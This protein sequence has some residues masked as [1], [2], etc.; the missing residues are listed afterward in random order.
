[1][2]APAR[3]GPPTA[4][5]RRA[6]GNVAQ[7]RVD[8]ST[9][10]ALS[11]ELAGD[12]RR[13]AF[14]ARFPGFE[15][16]E[17][18]YAQEVAQAAGVVEHHAVS[19]TADEALADLEQLVLDEEE[20][21]GSLSVYAQWRVMSEAKD[22]GVVVL[23]DG[24][25]DELFGGYPISEGF[26]LRATGPRE[27]A[28]KLATRPARFGVL[29]RSLA[30]DFLPWALRRAYW[31]RIASPYS[32]DEAARRA[33]TVR[34]RRPPWMRREDL[35]VREPD[36][37]VR[38]EPAPPPALRGQEQHGLE[39]RA[40]PSVPRPAPGRASH[41]RC[42]R[43]TSTATGRASRSCV[44]S[45]AGACP[46]PSS[47]AASRSASSPH[48]PSGSTTRPSASG[49]QRCCSIHAPGGAGSTTTEPSRPTSRPARGGTRTVSGGRSTP[50]SGCAGW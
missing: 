5:Q 15:R 45:V 49:S 10:V 1:M 11:A 41:S 23:L 2:R 34:Q 44:T 48:R 20:P 9:V 19:P 18:G 27:A 30:M 42:R 6:C 13:H 7:R 26:A 28:R 47:P 4:A 32:S 16:D 14:T 3:L 29:G 22:A 21:V 40:A 39:P 8:S 25:G 35:L 17:W 24:Q 46:S 38:H 33:A 31:R 43:A 12:H 36:A 50:S 37:V